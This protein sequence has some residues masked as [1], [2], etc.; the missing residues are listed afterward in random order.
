MLYL[1][2][3]ITSKHYKPMSYRLSIEDNDIA[4]YY[5]RPEHYKARAIAHICANR[6]MTLRELKQ[7]GYTKVNTRIAITLED[8]RIYFNNACTTLGLEHPATIEIGHYID[9]YKSGRVGYEWAVQRAA[10]VYHNAI[11]E[12][13]E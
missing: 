2:V 7:Y 10:I 12:L 11:K 3:E 6:G 9:M 5:G 4:D 8:I 1:Y 13:R